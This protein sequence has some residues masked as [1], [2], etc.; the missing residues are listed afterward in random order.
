[1]FRFFRWLR[2]LLTR[3]LPRSKACHLHAARDLEAIWRDLVSESQAY[4]ASAIAGKILK[5]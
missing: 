1:M 3:L 5:V 4:V 2:N